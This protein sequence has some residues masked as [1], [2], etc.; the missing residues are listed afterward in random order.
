MQFD[1]TRGNML[2]FAEVANKLKISSK[3]L[4]DMIKRHQFP[5]ADNFL[6]GVSY[7]NQRSVD[8]WLTTQPTRTTK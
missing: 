4:D 7:W 8:L 6:N 5:V 3:H 2:T 1:R